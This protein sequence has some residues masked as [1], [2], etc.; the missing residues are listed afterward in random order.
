MSSLHRLSPT[1]PPFPVVTAAEPV[2]PWDMELIMR[3]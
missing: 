1:V 2:R 3:V